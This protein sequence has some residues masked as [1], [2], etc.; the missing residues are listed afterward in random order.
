MWEEM[1]A[2]GCSPTV[3]SYTAYMKDLFHNCRLK[4]AIVAF[5]EMLQSGLSPNCH[6]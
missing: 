6:A 2:S 3:V 4:E 5:R 1:K